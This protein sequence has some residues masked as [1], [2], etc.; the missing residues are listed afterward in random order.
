MRIGLDFDNTII[1]YDRVFVEVGRRS[2]RV[3]PDFVGD[4][5][6]IRRVVRAGPDGERCWTELQAR[7]YGH[8]IARAVPAPGVIAFL[9][10][11]RR[12]GIPLFVV[13][14]KT[15]TAQAEPDGPNLRQ[16]ARGW[17]AAR[18]L[19]E[20]VG[21]PIVPAHVHFEATRPDK[22]ARIAALGCTHFIDDL[23]EVFQEPAF[24]PGVTRILYRPGVAALPSGPFHAFAGW[25]EIA[26]ALFGTTEP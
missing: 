2:G 23:E 24:P 17:L 1:R 10:D 5:A 15:E 22:L 6:A 3:P 4:K 20:G 16:A 26:E 11:A 7:V 19:T 25:Y 14:H 9:Y 12:R 21:G 18:G 13:S 8:E